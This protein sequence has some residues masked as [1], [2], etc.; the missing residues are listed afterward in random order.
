[1]RV[2]LTLHLLADM[3]SA[4][5]LLAINIIKEPTPRDN[6]YS[7]KH[8]WKN[9]LLQ[10]VDLR[11]NQLLVMLYPRDT[12]LMAVVCLN[13]EHTFPCSADIFLVRR[14][15]PPGSWSVLQAQSPCTCTSENRLS[16]FCCPCTAHLPRTPL[17]HWDLCCLEDLIFSQKRARSRISPDHAIWWRPPVL[18]CLPVSSRCKHTREGLQPW[19]A[20][21]KDISMVGALSWAVLLLNH[22]FLWSLMSLVLSWC[23]SAA[24]PPHRGGASGWVLWCCGSR[25][26]CPGCEEQLA[27]GDSCFFNSL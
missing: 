27:L 21:R 1:M 19:W 3:F 9:L 24:S 8:F 15:I 7:F 18:K 4:I 26:V 25:T 2:T 13:V 14:L 22:N 16:L 6:C 11:C 10:T 23:V 5:S 17:C 12:I 20:S